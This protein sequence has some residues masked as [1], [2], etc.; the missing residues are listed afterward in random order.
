V[1]SIVE[2]VFRNKL[3][4]RP[5]D[6]YVASVLFLLGLYGIVDEGFPE[7]AVG[8]NYVWL[9]H[10]ICLYF[11]AASAV[12]IVSLLCHR[13]KH[14]VM[15]L[16]GEIYGWGFIAAAATATAL[17][18]LSVFF[19]GGAENWFSWTI[20][21]TIWIGMAVASLFRSL[22]LYTFYRSLKG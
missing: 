4:E 8:G 11:M 3:R 15:A 5:F 6:V 16:M 22:D 17:S 19:V 7:S 14:P 1:N 12:V 10:L 21:L 18:Y 9:L 13:Q 20:W 2:G